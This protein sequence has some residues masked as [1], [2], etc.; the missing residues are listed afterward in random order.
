MKIPYTFTFN[1]PLI[2]EKAQRPK[3]SS[4]RLPKAQTILYKDFKD[5][6]FSS[7]VANFKPF[8]VELLEFNNKADFSFY[9]EI[10]SPQHFIFL[11]IKGNVSFCTPEGFFVSNAKHG[12]FALAY[13][14]TGTYQVQM[15]TGIHIAL[16]ISIEPSWLERKTKALT[17][18]QTYLAS[19]TR[20]TADYAMLPYCFMD[21]DLR[22]LLENIHSR[23]SNGLGYIEGFLRMHIYRI[24]ERYE[25]LVSEKLSSLP[26]QALH[27]IHQ[28]FCD[29]NL[30]S[31][32]IALHFG[33]VERSLR[34]QFKTEFNITIRDCYTQ[35]RVS[36]A[37]KLMKESNLGALDIYL[38]VGYKDV[39]TLRY[40]LK[41]FNL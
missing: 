19:I 37:K 8:Y 31:H 1:H 10:D 15:D 30:D 11:L 13:N 32:T 26:Y 18:L 24:L 2:T 14:N 33:K 4:I 20:D 21:E 25:V 38:Q 29:P 40:E 12:H 35:L 27:Y 16:C 6:E 28:N 23:L 3:W 39:N 41:R 5:I 7:Q 22:D 9:Y 36:Y 17:T 34:N